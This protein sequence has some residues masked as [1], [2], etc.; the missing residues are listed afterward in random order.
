MLETL[1]FLVS[2]PVLA[3]LLVWNFAVLSA[4]QLTVRLIGA[5]S[6]LSTMRSALILTVVCIPIA[7]VFLFASDLTMNEEM[8]A[9]ARERGIGFYQAYIFQQRMLV[10][11]IAI[12]LTTVIGFFV[13]RATLRFKRTRS[14]VVA[15]IGI[16]VLSAPWLA[17]LHFPA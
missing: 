8:N 16:G 17:F 5:F 7:A 15:A 13:I 11:P 14:A 9:R 3:G 2:P 10:F 1:L 4:V 6:V 12:L